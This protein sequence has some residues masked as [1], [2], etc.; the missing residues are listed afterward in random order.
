M[1]EAQQQSDD[2]KAASAQPDF[3]QTASSC[4]RNAQRHLQALRSSAATVQ[5]AVEV[6]SSTNCRRLGAFAASKQRREGSRKRMMLALEQLRDGAKRPKPSV[7]TS[8]ILKI[9]MASDDTCCDA[10]AYETAL[11]AVL[12]DLRSLNFSG[13]VS[14]QLVCAQGNTDE[15]EPVP[16]GMSATFG[17][18]FRVSIA[19]GVAKC[20]ETDNDA[21]VSAGETNLAQAH[22]GFGTARVDIVASHERPLPHMSPEAYSVAQESIE[23]GASVW[24]SSEFAVFR[25]VS[26]HA[27]RAFWHFRITSDSPASALA[28]LFRWLGNYHNI[29]SARCTATGTRLQFSKRVGTVLPPTFRAHPSGDAYHPQE[30]IRLNGNLFPSNLNT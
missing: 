10:A 27:Q 12:Q 28:Q 20:C 15:R 16:V 7:R 8:S 19:F 24:P 13:E 5:R 3:T 2:S 14:Y 22:D 26:L 25:E 4:I 17:T 11:R 23:M 9:E 6:V 21:S 30:Y 1:H 29:F 18:L